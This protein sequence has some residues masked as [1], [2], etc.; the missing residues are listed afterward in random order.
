MHEPVTTLDQRYSDPTATA[1]P[2][3]TTRHVLE[4]AELFWLASVRSDGR[5]HATPVVAVWHDG[6]LYFTTG[7]TE[8]KFRNLRGNPHMLL[9]TGS[10]HWMKGWTWWLRA[11]PCKSGTMR[12]WGASP[13][14]GPR[15][16]T[17]GGTTRCVMGHLTA[18]RV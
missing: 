13:S 8:Q 5:P 2:W 10:T 14:Y 11:M 15:N 6:A 3:E 18:E 7:A 17:D 9:T 1:T 16:G 4:T 12:C